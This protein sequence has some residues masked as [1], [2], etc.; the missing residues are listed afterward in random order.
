MGMFDNTN[1]SVPGGWAGGQVLIFDLLDSYGTK[2]A[3]SLRLRSG[4]ALA[5]FARVGVDEANGG[6]SLNKEHS[7]K[8]AT[9][10]YRFHP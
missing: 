1:K 6:K 3:S 8:T 4:Q 10:R 9:P 2:S 5:F 7:E